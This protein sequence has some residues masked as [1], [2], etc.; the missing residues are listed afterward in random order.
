MNDR[1]AQIIASQRRDADAKIELVRDMLRTF[2]A[3]DASGLAQM[4]LAAE[5]AAVAVRKLY[6]INLD[7]VEHGLA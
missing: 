5:N 4:A 2:D 7:G 1:T 6:Q 3:T